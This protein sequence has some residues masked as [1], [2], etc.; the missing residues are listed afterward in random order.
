MASGREEQILMSDQEVGLQADDQNKQ[1][2]ID[3]LTIEKGNIAEMML[4][5]ISCKWPKDYQYNREHVNLL[6]K[7]LK[8]DYYDR[9]HF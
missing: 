5:Q 1:D 3:I 4:S 6:L 2:L 9:Y 8:K 7:D